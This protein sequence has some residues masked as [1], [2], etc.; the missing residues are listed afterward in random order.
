MYCS[1]DGTSAGTT[2]AIAAI[3]AITG[4]WACTAG[5]PVYSTP[6]ASYVDECDTCDADPANDCP[7]DCQGVF[8]GAAAVAEC[9]L[10]DGAPFVLCDAACTTVGGLDAAT[11]TKTDECA[12]DPC[13][14]ALALP[15]DAGGTRHRHRCPVALLC[16]D[17]QSIMVPGTFSCACRCAERG[18]AQ[19]YGQVVLLSRAST[20]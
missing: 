14:T 18:V 13:N 15:D 8:G 5:A 7:M 6:G 16:D 9:V 2:E 20:W 11:A 19:P 12:A 1:T 4:R 10:P 17:T 3:D